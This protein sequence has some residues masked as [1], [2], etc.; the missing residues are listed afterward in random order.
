MKA[1]EA[2]FTGYFLQ[3]LGPSAASEAKRRNIFELIKGA[4]QKTYRKPNI[5]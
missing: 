2:Q 5:L 3:K 1:V 4:I